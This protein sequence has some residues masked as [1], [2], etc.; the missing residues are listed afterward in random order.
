MRI[1]IKCI[2]EPETWISICLIVQDH[3]PTSDSEYT[4]QDDF[5]CENCD[6]MYTRARDLDI[7]MSYCTGS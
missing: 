5:M 7:H 4:Q 1:M 6:K 3:S 2:Q